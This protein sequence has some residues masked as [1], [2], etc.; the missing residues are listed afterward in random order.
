MGT[1]NDV[2]K[3]ANL[4]STKQA[5]LDRLRKRAALTV[6]PAIRRRTDRQRAPLSFSQQR[7]LLIQQLDLESY[8]YNVAR[9]LH[10]RGPLVISDLRDALNSVLDRHEILR[11]ACLAAATVQ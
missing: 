6:A 11:S 9:A 8:L 2:S 10:I 3:L 7:L 4:S 1:K 5:L